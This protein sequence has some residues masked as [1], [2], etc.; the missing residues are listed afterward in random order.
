MVSLSL[1]VVRVSVLSDALFLIKRLMLPAEAPHA[2][3]FAVPL[4][5]VLWQH[6]GDLRPLGGSNKEKWLARAGART[7][8]SELVCL[9][10]NY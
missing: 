9:T 7:W 8:D 6:V 2:Y 4:K 10:A 3:N 5:I 1:L